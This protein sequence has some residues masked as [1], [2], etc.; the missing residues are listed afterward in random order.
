MVDLI[1]TT[2]DCA[3]RRLDRVRRAGATSRLS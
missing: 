3:L 1:L 2:F